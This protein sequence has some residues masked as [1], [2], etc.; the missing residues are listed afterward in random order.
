MYTLEFQVQD[1][2]AGRKVKYFLRSTMQ[3]S[4]HQS[5]VLKA[6]GGLKVNGE[7]VHANYILKPGDVVT[8]EL[9]EQG[10]Q[11]Q[12]L[13][14]ALPVRIVYEDDDLCIVDKP[15]PLACQSTP[16]QPC[17]TLENRMHHRYAHIENYV[18]RPVNRLDKGTSGLMAVAKHAHAYQ[19]MQRQLHSDRFIRE[20]TAIVEG[21]LTGEGTIDLP[22]AKVP[23]ATVRRYIDH[24]N[25]QRAVTHYRCEI[26]R[27]GRT[28][29]RLRLET[30]RTHQIRVH[31]AASGHPIAGDFLYGSELD[32]LPGRFA[33]H[34]CRIRFM[35][36]ISGDMLE[37]SSPLPNELKGLLE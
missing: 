28:Q 21:A 12:V 36:P 18:F 3:L 14:E 31:M 13:P 16:K 30:G 29:V 19:L 9:P 15:A 2:D 24:E 8:A 33:L 35:H 26:C 1:A 34:S 20:Y 23:D 25:G 5:A 6:A 32:E 7:S 27:N 17:G 10:A 22:I 4:Y 11:K 37:C